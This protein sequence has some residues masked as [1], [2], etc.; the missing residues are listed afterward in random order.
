MNLLSLSDVLED[1]AEFVDKCLGPLGSGGIDDLAGYVRDFIVQLCATI[2]IFLLIKFLLWK[3]ITNILEQKREEADKELEEARS[4]SENAKALEAELQKQ[5]SEA[6]IE[7]KAILDSAEMDA[8]ARRE[9]I[10]NEAKAEAKRRIQ[11]AQEEI[12]QE[13]KNKHAEIHQMIVSTAFEAA[14]KILEHEVDKEKYLD[15]VNEIIE[16]ATK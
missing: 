8:N 6:Q 10:I 11:L 7:V 1:I 12:E 15:L 9:D 4:A 3:P 13:V 16:G 5:M 14:S 2:I